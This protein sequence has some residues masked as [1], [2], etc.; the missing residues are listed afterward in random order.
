MGSSPL[1]AGAVIL[2]TGGS[3][4]ANYIRQDSLALSG[5]AGDPASYG[6]LNIR[7]KA[8]GGET[9][10]VNTLSIQTDGGGN[11]LGRLDLAD[12]SLIVDYS[13]ASPLMTMRALILSGYAGGSWTGNGIT[14]SVAAVTSLRSLGY[15]EASKVLGLSGANTT[16]W[17]GQTVDATSVLVRYTL[18]GDANLD[19]FVDLG[20]LGGAVAPNYGIGSGK[21]WQDGDFNGDGAVDLSDLALLAANYGT[22]LAAD[23]PVAFGSV[24]VPE[25]GLLPL[26]GTML[27]LGRR[28]RA[29]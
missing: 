24:P 25:P 21:S 15:G 9:S 1:A 3:I 18:V 6:R 12:N 11:P 14:S 19:G 4:T 13:S 17:E 22:A 8:D 23:L 16:T 7:K 10:L 2:D 29:R 28:R 5:N 27:L 26:A 20:D